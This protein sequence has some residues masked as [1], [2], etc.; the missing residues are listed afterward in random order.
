MHLTTLTAF[1]LPLS[2]LSLV[3]PTAEVFLESL[4]DAPNTLPAKCSKTRLR[5]HHRPVETPVT[6]LSDDDDDKDPL[7]VVIWHGLGDS[8]DADGL[9]SMAQLINDIN[10]GTYVHIISLGGK[11][12]A[13]DRQQTFFGNV[14]AQVEQVCEQLAADPILKTAP[15][16]DAI[17]FS[18]GG[19]FLRAY[20]EKCTH[21]APKVRSLI[22]FGSQHNGISEFERC[23]S[24]TDWVCQGA[25]ALLKSSTVWS[26]FVQSRLVPAQYFREAE[27][28]DNYLKYSNFL[29]DVN[30]ERK[31]KNGTYAKNLGALEKFVMVVF[32]DDVTVV[33]RESGWFS[34]VNLTAIDDGVKKNVTLLRDRQ[35]YKEDWIGLKA[36]DE[37]N[38]LVFEEIKGKHMELNDKD[39]KRLFRT[40][41]GEEGKKFKD[42]SDWRWEL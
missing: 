11:D 20:V 38:G 32:K 10:P 23:E 6:Y 26:N 22:T 42:S 14:T 5:N 40:Y 8:A 36:L 35:I 27:D 4:N 16:I 28:Y 9:K 3:L 13:P 37:K 33:P 17:G 12:G 7:P 24:A 34:E 21:W 29:A 39:L 2:A 19:Q 1:L 41:F 15:A 30:N 18:Q 25:N 31:V